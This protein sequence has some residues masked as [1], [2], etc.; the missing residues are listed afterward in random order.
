MTARLL[1]VGAGLL[2]AAAAATGAGYLAAVERPES[3]LRRGRAALDRGDSE[4]AFRLADGLEQAGHRDHARLLRG[5]AW[6]RAGRAADQPAAARPA[7]T[8]ALDNLTQ[9]RAEHGLEVEAAV[10]GAE[11]LLH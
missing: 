9:M 6:L 1:S 11:C 4:Q 3:L 2:V 7:L 10:L 8:R 5:D